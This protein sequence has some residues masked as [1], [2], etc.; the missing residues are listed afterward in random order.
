MGV[1]SKWAARCI[2]ILLK[3]HGM[4]M[5]LQAGLFGTRSAYGLASRA[6]R[7]LRACRYPVLRMARAAATHKVDRARVL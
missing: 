6:L 4:L 7:I 2:L 1:L 3:A 5:L